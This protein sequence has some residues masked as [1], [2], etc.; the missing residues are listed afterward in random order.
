MAH[1]PRLLLTFLVGVADATRFLSSAASTRSQ[2]WHIVTHD[3]YDGYCRW[4][5]DGKSV[6][7]ADQDGFIEIGESRSLLRL[8]SFV[9][10]DDVGLRL[11]SSL[12]LILLA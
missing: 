9:L 5:Q 8:P 2:L 10:V 1:A 11:M 12:S 7:L 4:S 6:V 3:E